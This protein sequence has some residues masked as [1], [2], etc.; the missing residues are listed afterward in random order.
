MYDL[1]DDKNDNDLREMDYWIQ[2]IQEYNKNYQLLSPIYVIGNKLDI[3]H[4][5]HQTDN[6]YFQKWME[7]AAKIEEKA[8]KIGALSFRIS[9]VTREGIDEMMTTITQNYIEKLCK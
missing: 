8:S 4:E 3:I 2:Q 9:C 5:R 6:T 1:S 7:K